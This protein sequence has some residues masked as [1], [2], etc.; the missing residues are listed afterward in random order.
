[1]VD[2]VWIDGNNTL[3]LPCAEIFYLIPEMQM[4]ILNERF[5][6]LSNRGRFIAKP[7]AKITK[8]AGN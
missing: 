7:L 2:H 3:P 6:N 1:M 8:V 4:S 5:I